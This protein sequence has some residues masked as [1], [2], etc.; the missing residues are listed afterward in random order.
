[1]TS[2]DPSSAA[3][4]S[5]LHLV[6][7]ARPANI[8]FTPGIP[9]GVG[10]GP[11][12]PEGSSSQAPA[13]PRASR[14][15]PPSDTTADTAAASARP[16]SLGDAGKFDQSNGQSQG[17]QDE[18][19]EQARE[20]AR[21]AAA[22]AEARPLPTLQGESP[23]SVLSE[24][25][26]KGSG[27][28]YLDV[29]DRIRAPITSTQLSTILAYLP[30]DPAPLPSST[31]TS[32]GHQAEQG[33]KPDGS[34][35][36][37]ANAYGSGS[38]VAVQRAKTK[39][40]IEAAL[41]AFEERNQ[42]AASRKNESILGSDTPVE[43]LVPPAPSVS[44]LTG[45][46]SSSAPGAPGVSGAGASGAADEG[47]TPHQVLDQVADEL[48]KTL[49]TPSLTGRAAEPSPSAVVRTGGPVLVW[50]DEGKAAT[51]SRDMQ[52]ILDQVVRQEQSRQE[53]SS[54]CCVM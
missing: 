38:Q 18:A 26:S 51:S 48:A 29:Q 50:W 39:A 21:L 1:M 13:A 10:S 24:L 15:A 45:S 42:A 37:E 4:K 6:R 40:R 8:T 27:G 35:A 47:T 17:E 5:V 16:A 41:R 22:Q 31:T 7:S 20:E 34:P 52:A 43:S 32:S 53:K 3:G 54:T 19:E 44:S 33:V 46:S 25:A 12:V 23:S 28:F 14:Q 9:L 49:E 11:D 2:C 36:A 30:R